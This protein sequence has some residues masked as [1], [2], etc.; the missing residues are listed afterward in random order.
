MQ[1][2]DDESKSL[3][4]K[5]TMPRDIQFTARRFAD[6]QY[7]KDSINKLHSVISVLSQSIDLTDLDGVTVAFDYEEALAEL[8]RGYDTNYKLTPTTDVAIGIAMAPTVIRDGAIKTHLV[9][10]ANYALSVLEEPGQETDFFRQSLHLIAHECAHVEVTAAFNKVFPGYLLQHQHTNLLDNY[11]WQ[12]ILAAWD[13]YAVC[14]IA[15]SIGF[16][17]TD[18]YR[19]TLLKV[20]GSTRSQCF[21]F[22]KAYRNHGDVERVVTEVYGKLGDLVKYS[23]YFLGAATSQGKHDLRPDVLKE[24]DEFIWFDQFYERSRIALEKLWTE[25]GEWQSQQLFEDLGDIVEDMAES[26]GVQASRISNDIVYF[27][28]PH[29]PES[30]PD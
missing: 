28:I 1:E 26:I 15:E 13:E 4:N 5:L 29:R 23:S 9:L 25:F 7:A 20:L 27:S 24:M 17:P 22:I 10:N 16:D 2:S 21:E 11:R 19:E 6:E 30:M 8:D 18:G 3:P 12:V 14:R